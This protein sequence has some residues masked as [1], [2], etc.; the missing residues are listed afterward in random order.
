MTSLWR[1]RR[2][3]PR[4]TLLLSLTAEVALSACSTPPLQAVAPTVPLTARFGLTDS[5]H[6]DSE[7]PGAAW[8]AAWGDPTLTA[9]VEEALGANH[10]IVIAV[11]RVAEARA[12]ADAQAS[13]LWPAVGVHASASRSSS[14]SGLPDDA[15]AQPIL[16]RRVDA[17][18][19]GS[20]DLALRKAQA[21]ANTPFPTG[22]S[23]SSPLARTAKAGARCQAWPWRPA[24]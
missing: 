14:G 3:G 21:C 12:G 5:A 4:A 20:G 9:L 15:G 17:A 24:S 18:C 23:R 7:T 2:S 8:W 13:R 1:G 19:L 6:G 11:H 16:F 10:D 22:L